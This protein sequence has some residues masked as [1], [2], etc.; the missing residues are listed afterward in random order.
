MGISVR[1]AVSTTPD[2]A[3]VSPRPTMA[4]ADIGPQ[5]EPGELSAVVKDSA[6]RVYGKQG[7][8]AAHLGKD[9]GNF[10]RDVVAGRMT[11]SELHKLGPA[12]LAEFGKE[13]VE[14]YAALATPQA[15]MRQQIKVARTALDEL[16]QGLE[17]IA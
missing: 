15:R 4:K 9:E 14:Q 8:A 6:R 13:L 11:L 1:S 17:H 3:L 16:E 12:F 2:K 10:A 7:A 5:G